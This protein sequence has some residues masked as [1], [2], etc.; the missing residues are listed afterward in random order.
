MI[1]PFRNRYEKCQYELEQ[2][3]KDREGISNKF[4]S[5]LDQV[6]DLEQQLSDLRKKVDSEC[7]KKEI[8]AKKLQ[9]IIESNPIQNNLFLSRPIRSSPRCDHDRNER[10]VARRLEQ[11]L[12][13]EHMNYEK[14]QN[15]K[16]EELAR[17]WEDINKLKHELETR[18]VEIE[19]YKQIVEI[20]ES[21]DN[22][23][24]TIDDRGI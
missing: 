24:L 13:V 5:I 2:A 6:H 1:S 11:V 14:L 17:L 18:K 8:A 22:V 3:I 20:R 23:L 7:T 16:N 19:K 9:E 21:I 12:E 10:N 15:E 4:K